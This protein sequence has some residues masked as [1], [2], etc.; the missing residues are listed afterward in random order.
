[1]TAGDDVR[2]L[3]QLIRR[4]NTEVDRY[5]GVL[6]TANQLHRT[7][8]S[9]LAAIVD[10]K[11]AGQPIGPSELARTLRL[12]A[13]A[14]TA[15][16]DR[17]ER[18]GHVERRRSVTDRRKIELHVLVRAEQAAG[19]M[20]VPLARRMEVMLAGFD[21][22]E[23]EVIH[24]FLLGGIEVARESIEALPDEPASEQH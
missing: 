24:R 3:V 12:S 10:A 8:L 21:P 14:T 11:A 5:V 4:F 22:A 1:M 17:M 7:D 9:A 23:R 15:L 19:R 20:F 18:A 16:L 2:A 6:S 13:P